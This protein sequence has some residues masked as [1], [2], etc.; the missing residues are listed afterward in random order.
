MSYRATIHNVEIRNVKGRTGK[1]G[2]EYLVV[3]FEDEAGEPIHLVDKDLSRI[4]R[5]Q[6]GA[7]LDLVI[8]IEAGY[9]YTNVRIVGAQAV[10]PEADGQLTDDFFRIARRLKIKRDGKPVS[11]YD[12]IDSERL[13]ERIK[14]GRGSLPSG[15]QIVAGAIAS[16]AEQERRRKHD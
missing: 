13:S 1:D 5:Y 15:A 10:R 6:R 7:F 16:A 2:N 11:V 14:A 3:Y 12:W 9:R 8:E 4:G